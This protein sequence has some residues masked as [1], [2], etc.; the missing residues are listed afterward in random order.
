MKPYLVKTPNLISVLFQHQTWRFS[1]KKKHIYL[2]FD[3]GPTPE[4]TCWVLDILKEYNAFATFFCIGKNI[5]SH[6]AVFQKIIKN[7]HAVGNHTYEHL[8][9]W[10]TSSEEYFKSVLKTEKLIDKFNIQNPKFQA[11]N[12][13]LFRPPYGKIKSSQ[14][15]ALVAT[16]YNIVMWTVLSADFDT[17][18]NA[19]KC[20]ENVINNTENG[21]IIVFHDSVKA[22]DKLK[23]VLPKILIY[24][25][26][27]GY[28]FKKIG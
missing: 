4:V 24:F 9:G 17:T 18:I 28:A 2:T 1:T 22:F 5:K 21:T 16:N 7:G 6:P 25:S 13:K 27:K 10:K 26:E 20:L 3:D 15:K 12:S 8:N 11:A 23:E 14:T 19:E